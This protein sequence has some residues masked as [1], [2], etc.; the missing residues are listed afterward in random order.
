M[1]FERAQQGNT[2]YDDKIKEMTGFTPEEYDHFQQRARKAIDTNSIILLLLKNNS[3]GSRFMK[4]GHHLATGIIGPHIAYITNDR[5]FSIPDVSHI[6]PELRHL[7]NYIKCYG[8]LIMSVGAS[9]EDNRASIEG[10]FKNPLWVIDGKY[11]GIAMALPDM[12]GAVMSKYI[13]P[14]SAKKKCCE[15]YVFVTPYGSMQAILSKSLQPGD[16]YN[17]S[18]I[19]ITKIKV[20]QAA[21]VQP[22]NQIKIRALHRIFNQMIKG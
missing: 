21:D 15:R 19:D 13:L 8:N 10:I 18:G 9:L 2:S 3:N 5:C 7:S 16:G 14:A 17:K 22:E 12:V 20:S 4:T 6:K 11:G 1:L